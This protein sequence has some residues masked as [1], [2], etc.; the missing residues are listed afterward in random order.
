MDSSWV[1]LGRWDFSHAILVT[2]GKHSKLAATGSNI[3]ANV[4]IGDYTSIGP[5]VQMHTLFNHACIDNPS[6]VSTACLTGYPPVATHEKMVIGNDVWIGRNATLLGEITIGDGAIIGAFSVIAKSIPPYAVVVGNPA[7]IKRYR[8]TPEQIE[9]LLRI[10]WWNWSE[11]KVGEN[12]GD[13]LNIE[14]FLAKHFM[15]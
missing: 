7:I 8:F 11:E 4:T 12:I 10:Q 2:I 9:K 14:I 15:L 5:H 6:L 13:F 3:T 1:H